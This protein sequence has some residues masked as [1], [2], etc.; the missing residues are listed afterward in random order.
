VKDWNFSVNEGNENI[1]FEFSTNEPEE[2]RGK[3]RKFFQACG[4]DGINTPSQAL[5]DGLYEIKLSL[6]IEYAQ[7]CERGNNPSKEEKL[8]KLIEAFN[9]VIEYVESRL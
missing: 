1:N 3:L 9:K 6:E 8:S 7:T 2:I 4:V 5:D